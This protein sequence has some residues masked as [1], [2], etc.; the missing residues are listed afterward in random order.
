MMPTK[1]GIE[2]ELA[3]EAGFHKNPLEY[4][5]VPIADLKP[6]TLLHLVTC[7]YYDYRRNRQNLARRIVTNVTERKP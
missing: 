2:E 6:V 7:L 4:K 3:N 5:G 1:E